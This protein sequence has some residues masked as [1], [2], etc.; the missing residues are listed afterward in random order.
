MC[1]ILGFINCGNEELLRECNLMMIHR[2]PDGSGVKWFHESNSGLAHNRLSIIDLSEAASQPMH[3]ED[4][5]YWI[6]YNGEI[7]NFKDIRKELLKKGYKFYS[8]S[9]TEVILNAYIEWGEQCLQKFNGMFSFAIYNTLE[10][11]LFLA[12]DRIGIKPLYYANFNDSF[13][14]ASEIKAILKSSLIEKKAD[15]HAIHTPVHYQVSPYTGFKDIFKLLPGHYL[16]FENGDII[17]KNIGH[18]NQLKIIH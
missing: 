4:K 3:S 11:R 6:V 17:I 1:S 15:Y 18:F 8:E 13:I 14:F 12:R 2:G 10:K 7:Y 16:I 5:R 9:D